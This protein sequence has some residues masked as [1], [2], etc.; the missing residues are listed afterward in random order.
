[1]DMRSALIV[2]A[3][4]ATACA[5]TASGA[6]GSTDTAPDGT[7]DGVTDAA[8]DGAFDASPDAA[9]NA[10]PFCDESSIAI[11]YEI[12]GQA[13]RQECAPLSNG[14][15]WISYLEY[16]PNDCRVRSGSGTASFAT[17]TAG[18]GHDGQ[19]FEAVGPSALNVVF[20]SGS[21]PFCRGAPT[22]CRFFRA[23]CPFLVTRSGGRGEVAEAHLMSPCVLRNTFDPNPT[24]FLDSFTVRRMSIRGLLVRGSASSLDP[25][26]D[27]AV[28]CP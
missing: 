2:F 19:P 20:D 16:T 24:P 3:L 1:M 25:H 10:L 21:P 22:S 6:D 23:R 4:L 12:P 17:F 7:D 9:P 27:A 26:R 14:G 18:A 8:V 11:E 13:P 5:S 28:I 15:L